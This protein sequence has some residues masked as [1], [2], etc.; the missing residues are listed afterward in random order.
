MSGRDWALNPGQDGMFWN[1]PFQ[2]TAQWITSGPLITALR[3]GSGYVHLPGD[4]AAPFAIGTASDPLVTIV[5]ATG[6]LPNFTLHIPVGTVQELPITGTDNGLGVVD[7]TK[8]Y[9]LY[10][11]NTVIINTTTVQAS[12]TVITAHNG[13]AID[14]A[15]GPIMMDAV[16]GQPGTGNMFGI[17][18]DWELS[19]ANADPNYVI[20]HM[21][22]Y[23]MDP[24][25]MNSNAPIWPLLVIDTSFPNTGT[26]NQG[27]TVGIPASVPMPSGLTRG[28]QLLWNAFQQFGGFFYNVSGNGTMALACSYTT[29]SNATLANDIK[30]SFSAILPHLCILSNQTDINSMKGMVGGVRS[31][32]FPA[33]PL[34]DLSPTGG[35]EVAPSTM[36]AFFPSG[37]N[38]TPTAPNPPLQIPGAPVNLTAGTPTSTSVQL[39]WSA[40]SSGG[41]VA[42]YLIDDRVGNTGSFVQIFTTTGTT[43]DVTGLQPSTTYNFEVF[44]QNASGTGPASNVVSV[45]TPAAVTVASIQAQV[46]NLENIVSQLN[47]ILTSASTNVGQL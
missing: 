17:I 35:V 42:T 27:Y 6:A 10:Q 36:G 26:L 5:D 46:T 14:D 24:A 18:Q 29:S 2:T 16:T 33:P 30:S 12:G 13:I 22:Q 34:I 15:C 8:P 37:Y 45:T 39:S 3:Q 19:A 47:S 25:E 32:A 20:Q 41:A 40:P 38:V 4:F 11:L 1:L 9:A 31:D 44:G 43:F 23:S 7:R 28:G 21:L